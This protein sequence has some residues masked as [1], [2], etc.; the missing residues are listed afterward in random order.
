MVIG[1]HIKEPNLERM[2]TSEKFADY[3]SSKCSIALML[4]HYYNFVIALIS[5]VV[6]V[7]IPIMYQC[8]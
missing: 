4:L 3:A 6:Y 8:N 2:D 1:L 5:R 7:S